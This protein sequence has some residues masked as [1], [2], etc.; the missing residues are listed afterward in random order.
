M[1][2]GINETDNKRR[3]DAGR[4]LAYKGLSETLMLRNYGYFL[5]VLPAA[6]W[7]GA[8]PPIANYLQC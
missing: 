3:F 5:R 4:Y 8:K 6:K 7:G 2:R 1:R